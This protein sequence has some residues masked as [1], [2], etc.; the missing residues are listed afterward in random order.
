MYIP[1]NLPHTCA[2]ESVFCY[3]L[4]HFVHFVVIVYLFVSSVGFAA[5]FCCLVADLV[6][7]G[8][9]CWLLYCCYTVIGSLVYQLRWNMRRLAGV[10][11]RNWRV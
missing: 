6:C 1:H 9:G 11:G 2:I 5:E 8:S 4:L 10:C 3:I 7:F